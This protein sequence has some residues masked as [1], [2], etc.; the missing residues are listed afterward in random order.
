MSPSV[1]TYAAAL[2]ESPTDAALKQR[3]KAAVLA[4]LD[5]QVENTV[6]EATIERVLRKI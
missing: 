1:N 2:R 5:G 3:V 6:L 4:R